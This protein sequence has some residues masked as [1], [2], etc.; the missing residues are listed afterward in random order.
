MSPEGEGENLFHLLLTSKQQRGRSG[1]G[2]GG[3]G[4][5]GGKEVME[6]HKHRRP[7]ESE[8]DL[9]PE[10]CPLEIHERMIM[11]E[12]RQEDLLQVKISGKWT[13]SGYANYPGGS[14]Q[15]AARTQE[16]TTHQLK[17]A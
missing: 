7:S 12:S 15:P 4:E 3:Q 11:V 6:P 14:A 2:G 8:L 13:L 5:V 17:A 10:I 16:A 1:G 9:L